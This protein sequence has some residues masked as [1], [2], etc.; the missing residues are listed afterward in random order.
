MPISVTCSCGKTLQV[1]DDLAGKAVKCPSC[2]AVLKVGSGS[3]VA[4]KPAAPSRGPPARG[5]QTADRRSHR[6]PVLPLAQPSRLNRAPAAGVAAGS[7]GA[8]DRLFE[9][10]GLSCGRASTAQPVP[11]YCNPARCSAPNVV[12]I[13]KPAPSCK[14]TSWSW[15]KSMARKRRCDVP[16]MI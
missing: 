7:D 6:R 13:W 11:N 8:L 3:A 12:F 4:A 14:G 9:E 16:R 2:Q 5:R 1:R 10:E 15:K